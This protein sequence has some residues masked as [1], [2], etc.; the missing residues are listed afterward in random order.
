MYP[1]EVAAEKE[2]WEEEEEENANYET[3]HGSQEK[4]EAQIFEVKR[5]VAQAHRAHA[6]ANFRLFLDE[7]APG[8][9]NCR[10][11]QTHPSYIV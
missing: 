1:P 9:H 4:V 5:H 10:Q 3:I 11:G 6:L 8:D 7:N 2:F